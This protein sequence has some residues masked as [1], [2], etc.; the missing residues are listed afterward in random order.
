MALADKPGLAKWRHRRV[1]DFV[2]ANLADPIR[3]PD[4]ARAAGLSRMHFAAQFRASTGVRPHEFVTRRRIEHS[5]DLLRNSSLPLA[6]VALDVGFQSQAHFT[7]VFRDY[8]QE[9]PG[10]WRQ[11][12][13]LS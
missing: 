5:Q 13:R 12:H 3:L 10:R 2:E 9:T 1:V 11:L 6:Q 8:V 7:T 4:L